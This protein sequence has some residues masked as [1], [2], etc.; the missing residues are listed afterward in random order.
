[1]GKFILTAGAQLLFSSLILAGHHKIMVPPMFIL[2][3]KKGHMTIDG[4][5]VFTVDDISDFKPELVYITLKGH[6]MPGK[7]KLE[8][9]SGKIIK[10]SHCLSEHEVVL[11]DNKLPV[12]FTVSTPAKMPGSP[13]QNDPMSTSMGEV[14]LIPKNLYVTADS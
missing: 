9:D 4:Q 1:M 6:V 2:A 14:M 8:I 3:S 13:P 10:A 11:H 7:G 12:K 5:K